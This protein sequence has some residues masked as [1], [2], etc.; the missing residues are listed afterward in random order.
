MKLSYAN[1][2][3]VYAKAVLEIITIS[4]INSS[5]FAA[6][7]HSRM[8]LIM[9]MVIVVVLVLLVLAV[10][11]KTRDSPKEMEAIPGTLGWPIIGESLSFISEFSS[12][13]GIYSFINKRQKL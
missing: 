12:R 5:L 2:E 11:L 9:L 1:K 6:S 4:H 13:A 8:E 7:T 3:S 10:L